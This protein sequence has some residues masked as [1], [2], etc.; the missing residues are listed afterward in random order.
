MGR[1]AGAGVGSS[2][3]VGVGSSTGSTTVFQGKVDDL[4]GGG[5][6]FL[7]G[8]MI[9]SGTGSNAFASSAFCF[10][11]TVVDR[12]RVGGIGGWTAGIGTGRIG[13]D[14][15]VGSSMTLTA[16]EGK[17]RLGS[18]VPGT[19]V[20]RDSA[21][22][23]TEK[24]LFIGSGADSAEFSSVVSGVAVSADGM[25][26][27]GRRGGAASFG[28]GGGDSERSGSVREAIEGGREVAFP[29]L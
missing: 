27:T 17:P 5:G 11:G 12:C 28:I 19:G 4:G 14:R 1:G 25:R 9:G 10:Q 7:V 18:S 24:D 21:I 13:G 23:L 6:T 2:A 8:V 22:A 29:R 26:D 15:S 20:S 3:R 16:E